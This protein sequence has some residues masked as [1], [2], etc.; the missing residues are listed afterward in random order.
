M[1]ENNKLQIV[2]FFTVF[3]AVIVLSFFILKPY[4]SAL[5]LAL[6]FYI[7]FKPVH[8][9]VLSLVG[10][11]DAISAFFT[12]LIIIFA[13]FIPLT[14]F[15]A[16]LFNDARE[17]YFQI[18]S[19]EFRDTLL[20]RWGT[21]V[22]NHLAAAF[23]VFTFNLESYV[24]KALQ[25]LISNLDSVFSGLLDVL[26]NFFIMILALFYM[27]KD[28]RKFKSA[29]LSVSPL[30]DEYDQDIFSNVEKVV[31][32]VLRGSLL[33]AFIQGIMVIIGF[34][35]FGI[36]NPALWGSLAVFASLVP[37]VG[38]SIV[39]FPAVVYLFFSGNIF[40]AV[41]LLV[42]GMLLVGLIDNLLGPILMHRGISIHPLVIL[43]SVIGGIS[44]FGFVGFVAGPVALSLFFVLAKLYPSI[45]KN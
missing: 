37:S 17:F 30:R 1:T 43:L 22:E 38:T 15:G 8:K 11:R 16:L 2:F 42:W 24:S 40:G 27:L 9:K 19:D 33:I 12:I 41:G 21:L 7:I 31:N 23:P 44:L 13:I 26:I 29:F 3:I 5:F 14:I 10:D 39:I 4:L 25:W 32:S 35:I 28:G 18:L 6:I 36:P 20:A 45:L 34:A